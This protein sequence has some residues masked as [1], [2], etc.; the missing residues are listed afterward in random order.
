MTWCKQTRGSLEEWLLSPLATAHDFFPVTSSLWEKHGTCWAP[1]MA[2]ASVTT[3]LGDRPYHCSQSFLRCHVAKMRP[4]WM[5]RKKCVRVTTE[6]W[7]HRCILVLVH[8]LEAYLYSIPV[9]CSHDVHQVL[10]GFD[11][12]IRTARL[13]GGLFCESSAGFIGT[14][15]NRFWILK[16]LLLQNQYQ[17]DNWMEHNARRLFPVK[18]NME[19]QKWVL[20]LWVLPATLDAKRRDHIRCVACNFQ[21][22]A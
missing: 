1:F 11:P 14:S 9:W 20:W 10:T 12:Q 17:K 16:R 7:I 6:I 18:A 8:F 5:K 3:I 15:W 21:G 19:S 4:R 2:A 22:I 13:L